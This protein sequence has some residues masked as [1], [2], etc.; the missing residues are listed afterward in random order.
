MNWSA[1]VPTFMITLRE[2]LEAALVVGIVLSL[3]QQTQQSALR[4][5]V[6]AGVGLGILS[7]LL[8]GLG[9]RA[10]FLGLA[11]SDRPLAQLLEPSLLLGFTLTAIALLSWML[12]WMTQQARSLKGNLQGNVQTLLAQGDRAGWGLLG[13]VFIAVAREGFE[14]V[15]FLISQLQ[16]GWPGVMGAMAGGCGAILLGWMLFALGL[17]LNLRL[18]FQVM[19]G[20]LILIISGLVLSAGKGLDT[21]VLRLEALT[22]GAITLCLFS[23]GPQQSCMLGPLVWDSHQILSDQAFPGVFLK[24]LLGYRDH[25]FLIQGCAYLVF[26]VSLIWAYSRSLPPASAKASTTTEKPLA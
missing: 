17:N 2:G 18:F 21:V 14:T 8:L 6:F 26:L 24:A 1:A 20:C 11:Q 3:L 23:P 22:H 19:G 15:V 9:F 16:S 7:S 25:I 13:L 12:V 10:V 4:R 5:W